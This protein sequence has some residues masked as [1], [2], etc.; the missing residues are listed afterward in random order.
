MSGGKLH[1]RLALLLSLSVFIIP[2]MSKAQNALVTINPYSQSILIGE[3]VRV[4]INIATDENHSIIW[5]EFSDTVITQIE[6]IDY[7][8]VDTVYADTN[9]KENIQGFSK[10]LIITSF[11]SGLWAFPELTVWID[12]IP[13]TTESFLFEVNTV[14]VDTTKAFADIVNPIDLPMTFMEYVQK[15]YIYA[16]YAYLAIA[17]LAIIAYVI[18]TDY[19]IKEK[20]KRI[21]KKAAHLIALERLEQLKSE[22]LW[23]SGA[24]KAY[25]IQISDI[26]RQYLENRYN[27]P[28]LESTTDEIKHLLKQIR[29]EKN[30]RVEIIEALR[31]SDLVKFAKAMPLAEENEVCLETAYAL[32]ESTKL[33][34]VKPPKTE[35]NE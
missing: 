23:Q 25:H 3:Q 9:L 17:I 10:Q 12:S 31:I 11:D 18:G 19:V 30:L 34:E 27:I 8:K 2:F 22:G 24:Y 26:T 29:M 33:E 21:P 35:T 13:Y 20:K 7:S 16:V 4:D 28:V 32:V 1:I 15:Y 14:E 5:P 6:V